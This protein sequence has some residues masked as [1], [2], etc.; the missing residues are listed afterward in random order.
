[1][2]SDESA[3]DPVPVGE[4]GIRLGQLLK[5]TGVVD[6]GGAAHSLLEDGGVMVNGVVE[7]RRGRQ[8]AVGDTVAAAGQ[9]FLLT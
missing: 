4:A 9:S 7:V 5:L 6:T 3:P 8:L 2:T 1:M